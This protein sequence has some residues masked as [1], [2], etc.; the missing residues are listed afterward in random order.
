MKAFIDTYNVKASEGYYTFR[1]RK[2]IDGKHFGVID[3]ETVGK[4]RIPSLETGESFYSL[5]EY[6]VGPDA[7]LIKEILE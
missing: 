7:I 1:L 2:P 5:V 4:Q 6:K 3:H